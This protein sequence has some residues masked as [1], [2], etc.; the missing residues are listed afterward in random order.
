MDWYADATA[1]EGGVNGRIGAFHGNGT[2]PIGYSDRAFVVWLL[3]CA[4]ARRDVGCRRRCHCKKIPSRGG[5]K[6]P[7]CRTDAEERARAGRVA[8]GDVKAVAIPGRAARAPRPARFPSHRARP[9]PSTAD[10]SNGM[11]LGRLQHLHGA[12]LNG[13][14]R[15]LD[16]RR[17]V[18]AWH[19]SVQPQ[20][21]AHQQGADGQRHAQGFEA[22]QLGVRVGF[23]GGRCGCHELR[24]PAWCLTCITPRCAALAPAQSGALAAGLWP[25]AG[26]CAARLARRRRA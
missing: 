23:G 20:D 22:A 3:G 25:N 8:S 4:A 18:R 13:P 17:G 15:H 14:G 2:K 21:Q 16:A 1:S 6:Q 12:G 24:S 7:P 9:S 11:N 19:P 26:S 5:D 10:L